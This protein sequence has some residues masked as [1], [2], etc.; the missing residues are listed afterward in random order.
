MKN[1]FFLT[2]FFILIQA[3]CFSQNKSFENYYTDAKALIQ[4]LKTYKI[5]IIRKDTSFMPKEDNQR[6]QLKR[7]FA[8]LH[9][10]NEVEDEPEFFI[11]I[12]IQDTNIK[13]NYTLRS[14]D[15]NYDWYNVRF[16]YDLDF[17]I[18]FDALEKGKISMPLCGY[19][20]Y[21]QAYSRPYIIERL[22]SFNR[23]GQNY[24]QDATDRSIESQVSATEAFLEKRA[25]FS[26][27]FNFALKEFMRDKCK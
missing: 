18:E 23:T 3:I 19:R 27:E 5:I 4:N 17:S 1:G 24:R 9:T 25:E 13:V 11:K 26:N 21:D 10:K 15:D 7:V 14:S 16:L 22:N 12:I 8:F 2:A 20:H 6:N